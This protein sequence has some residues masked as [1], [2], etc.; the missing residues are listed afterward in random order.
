S[1][2]IEMDVGAEDLLMARRFASLSPQQLR[3]LRMIVQGRLN[4]QI[5]GELRVSEQTVK[6]HVSTIF[7]KLGVS[8]RT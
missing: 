8:T 1:M 2:A 6:I 3:I 7:R 5:A 4:K